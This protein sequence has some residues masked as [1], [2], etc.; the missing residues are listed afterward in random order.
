M[1]NRLFRFWWQ[2]AS[3]AGLLSLSM[4][5]HS[6][7]SIE[8]VVVIGTKDQLEKLAGSGAMLDEEYL[9]KRDDSDLHRALS[10]VPGLYIR[11][12]D[13][14]GLRP[15]IGIRGA[16][17]DRSQKITMMEDGVLIGPAP[18]SAPAAYYVPNVN[19]MDA[20]EVL[21]GPASIKY[22]PHTVGGAINFVTADVPSAFDAKASVSFGSDGY[23]KYEG[24]I[25]NSLGNAGFLIDGLRYSSDGFKS[26]DGGGDTGFVRNDINFKGKYVPSGGLPQ[27]ITLKIAWADEDS[28][29]TYLG[30][31]DLDFEK[32]PDRRY[33][34]SHL[35]GFDTEHRMLHLNYGI[36]LN[37]NLTVNAKAYWNEYERAWNK[38]DGFI[39]GTPAQRVLASPSLYAA[40]YQLLSGDRDS[41]GLD[42]QTID[43]TNNDREFTSFGLQGGISFAHQ[44]GGIAQSLQIGA[45]FHHDEVNREHRQRGYLMRGGRL[46]YDGVQR[47]NKVTNKGETDAVSVFVSNDF[48]VGP[49]TVSIGARYEDIQG[50]LKNFLT[51]SKAENDQQEWM[52]SISVFYELTETVSLLAGVHKGIS[53]SGPGATDVSAEESVN[54]EFGGRFRSG[55]IFGE[56]IGFQ[57]DYSNLLGRCR[58]SDFGCQP[59]EE[60]SGGEVEI[61]GIEVVAGFER[62]IGSNLDVDARL[63]YTYT[64]SEFEESFLSTFS[65][66]G[67]V[68]SGDELPYLPENILSASIDFSFLPYSAGLTFKHTSEMREEP[69]SGSVSL[70]VHADKQT[71]FDAH[72]RWDISQSTF[73]QVVI[74]NIS[75]EREIVAHRPFGARPSLPRTLILKIEHSLGI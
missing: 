7:T 27:V 11:E 61:Q 29:E 23:E 40:Q 49:A 9:D 45:R 48:Y 22:G 10:E 46:V 62:S 47:Q 16:T 14:F 39:S 2:S 74:R 3:L 32:T 12:E 53:P 8:E 73:T 69:G 18:Y 70:G 33:A 68:E 31:T 1:T 56:V 60:F 58:V 63:A 25:G 5:G 28:S 37:E 57:S 55:E 42:S 72:F 51:S 54:Y 65:Q 50:Q 6:D 64:Q 24:R 71:Y 30:L 13:G 21:K 26:L 41:N 36:E 20:V 59:G 17:T 66:F 19:R 15:N 38:F 44:L 35:D 75:D 52:P 67:I 43:V 4:V 34:A